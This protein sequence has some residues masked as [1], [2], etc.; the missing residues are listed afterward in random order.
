MKR[1]ILISCYFLMWEKLRTEP[2]RIVPKEPMKWFY[3]YFMFPPLYHFNFFFVRTI[4]YSTVAIQHE[5]FFFFTVPLIFIWF[6]VRFFFFLIKYLIT[7]IAFFSFSRDLQYRQIFFWLTVGD[8][9]WRE[10]NLF[11]KSFIGTPV[12][13]RDLFLLYLNNLT[14]FYFFF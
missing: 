2:S 7:L 12:D 4:V 14:I 1:K 13:V 9:V 11:F 5:C 10:C 8:V 6:F 3:T